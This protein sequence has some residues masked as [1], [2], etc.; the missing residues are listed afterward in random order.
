MSG[1]TSNAS[2]A[3]Q[4]GPLQLVTT[5]A[6][7]NLASDGGAFQRQVNQLMQDDKKLQAG[8]AMASALPHSVVLPGEKVAFD[9]NWANFAGSNA[10]GFDAAVKLGQLGDIN[11]QANAGGSFAGDGSSKGSGIAKAGLRFGW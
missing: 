10:V 1:I 7:G 5:D 8:V 2:K 9:V 3:A 6:N 11:V 4:S